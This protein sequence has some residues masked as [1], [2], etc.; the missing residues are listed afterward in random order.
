MMGK[1]AVE[2]LK[3]VNEFLETALDARFLFKNCLEE[4]VEHFLFVYFVFGLE[5]GPREENKVVVGE[6]V[7]ADPDRTAEVVNHGLVEDGSYLIVGENS[8]PFFFFKVIP[9]SPLG[10]RVV[11]IRV[12]IMRQ[13][14]G[15]GLEQKEQFFLGVDDNILQQCRIV[16]SELGSEFPQHYANLWQYRFLMFAEI[17]D[18][19]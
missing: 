13:Q 9:Y 10:G 14:L 4:D 6:E 19:F 18:H 11:S 7:S 16:I 2:I 17:F 12:G 15:N 8:F 3:M 5:L 1:G